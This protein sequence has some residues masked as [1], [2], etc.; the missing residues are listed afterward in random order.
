MMALL[1]GTYVSNEIL[2]MKSMEILEKAI[3][4]GHCAVCIGQSI[5]AV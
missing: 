2:D 3:W 5:R 1:K 4:S